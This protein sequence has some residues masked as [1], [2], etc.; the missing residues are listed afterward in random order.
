MTS[1]SSNSYFGDNDRFEIED[2][3]KTFRQTF[4][5]GQDVIDNALR[6]L[7]KKGRSEKTII[8]MVSAAV[9][10]HVEYS[11]IAAHLRHS[12]PEWSNFVKENLPLFVSDIA[13]EF[14]SERL[15]AVKAE[16]SDTKI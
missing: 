7:L 2:M 1:P 10:I 11:P 15:K 8:E 6:A 14:V 12:I 4:A 9:I 5:A 13:T 3:K 16:S